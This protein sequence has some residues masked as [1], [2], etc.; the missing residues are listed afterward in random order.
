[1]LIGSWILFTI[2]ITARYW[3]SWTNAIMAEPKFES[4]VALIKSYPNAD[5]EV[6]DFYVK[7]GYKGIIIEGTGL[8]HAPVSTEHH[9]LLMVGAPEESSR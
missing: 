7:K 3:R 4:K 5:P 2:T 9:E 6:I 8:G 1:M